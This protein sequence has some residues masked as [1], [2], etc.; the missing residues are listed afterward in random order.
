MKF[1]LLAVASVSASATSSVLG[2]PHNWAQFVK[3]GLLHGGYDKPRVS[4]AKVTW[5]Q[6][7]DQEGIFHFDAADSQTIPGTFKRGDSVVFDFK[8]KFDRSLQLDKYD[9]TVEYK[10]KKATKTFAGAKVNGNWWYEQGEM[11][12]TAAPGGEY[13]LTIQGFNQ[14]EVA[15]C[16]EGTWTL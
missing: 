11:I 8:G 9:I 16:A 3:T 6:C 7:A 15:M 2:D 10:G 12:P 4:E 14:G 13:T 1:S 5:S